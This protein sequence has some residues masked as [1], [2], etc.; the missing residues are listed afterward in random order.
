MTRFFF[1]R[2]LQLVWRLRR[3]R[4]F[5]NF[6]QC[7]WWRLRRRSSTQYKTLY[8]CFAQPIYRSV[9]TE[10]IFTPTQTKKQSLELT[11]TTKEKKE[12]PE[13]TFSSKLNLLALGCI[14]LPAKKTQQKTLYSCYTFTTEETTKTKPCKR[15]AITFRSVPRRNYGSET[16]PTGN[17]KF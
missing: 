7:H 9:I 16:F 6:W 1:L 4:S 14:Q 2:T 17:K 13:K 15:K 5:Q 10:Q 11:K 3:H 8:F 12:K